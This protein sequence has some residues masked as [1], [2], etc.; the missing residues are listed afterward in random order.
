M[1]HIESIQHL[2][3]RLVQQGI[4][5]FVCHGASPFP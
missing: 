5:P 2:L 4:R 1:L 3:D